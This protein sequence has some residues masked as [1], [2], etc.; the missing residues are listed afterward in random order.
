MHRVAGDH[1]FAHYWGPLPLSAFTFPHSCKSL[2]GLSSHHLS[3]IRGFQH[4][5]VINNHRMLAGA[6]SS[7]FTLS[8]LHA[9][10]S[11]DHFH[12]FSLICLSWLLKPFVSFCPIHLIGLSLE[13]PNPPFVLVFTNAYIEAVY[14]DLNPRVI[15]SC[16]LSFICEGLPSHG[17]ELQ[18]GAEKEQC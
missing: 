12:A 14:G 2:L 15:A 10:E 1:S 5:T 6:C 17:T 8:H 16:I 7:T 9:W 13:L 4:T 3:S 18:R 11:A